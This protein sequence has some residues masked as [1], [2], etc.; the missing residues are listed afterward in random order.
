MT[1]KLK[2]SKV[3][4]G[5]FEVKEIV[6]TVIKNLY[7]L[8]G[9]LSVLGLGIYAIVQGRDKITAVAG[10]FALILAGCFAFVVGAALLTHLLTKR[11]PKKE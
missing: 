9:G 4:K 7:Y 2:D 1:D 6:E 5:F 11:D 8:V 10:G 3:Y